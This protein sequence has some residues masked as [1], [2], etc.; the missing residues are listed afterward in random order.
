L[1]GFI[2]Q[3]VQ[4]NPTIK[5]SD[6]MET[7]NKNLMFLILYLSGIT[8]SLSQMKIP[9][10]MGAI[11]ES[12][13][14]SFSQASWLMSIF[15]LA[16]IVLAI[17]G[18]G[19]MHKVGPKKLL[20]YLMSA[21]LIGNL[22]GAFANS[23]I[24]LLISRAIE[25]IA[26]ALIIMVGL[27]M[28]NAWYT[29]STVGTMVGVFNTFG[30]VGPFVAMNIAIPIVSRLGLKS[31][32]LI[33]AGISAV[34]IILI[35]TVLDLPKSDGGAGGAKKVSISEAAMNKSVWLLALMQGCVVFILFSY[36]TTYPQIFSQF[37]K[38]DSVKANFYSSLKGLFGIPF[39]ILGGAIV[40]KTGKP[41]IVSLASFLVLIGVGFTTTLLG[42]NTYVL[43]IL[44]GSIFQGF[45]LT[46]VFTMAPSV[47]KKPAYIGLTIAFVNLL[48]YIAVFASTPVMLGVAEAHSW[49]ASKNILTA[50]AVAGVVITLMFI[51]SRSEEKPVSQ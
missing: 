25:G 10:V 4:A 32:W 33:I 12:L 47:A 40:D 24:L 43:H 8:I 16:G 28:V 15:T 45:I 14:I 19:I 29:G 48:Y 20:T 22:I 49:V 26:F 5:R 6:K 50:V 13:N 17:P 36:L 7:K 37:Y 31:L 1:F 39:V 23:F 38:L 3:S 21:V 9:P 30:A 44:I 35:V 18:A 2:V 42:P 11:T 27:V 46:S 51:K 34:L 41:A